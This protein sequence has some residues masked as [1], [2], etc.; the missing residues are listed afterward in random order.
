MKYLNDLLKTKFINASAQIG[1]SHLSL[2]EATRWRCRLERR[3][4]NQLRML[5]KSLRK[6][7]TERQVG[8]EKSCSAQD[9]KRENKGTQTPATTRLKSGA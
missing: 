3:A 5:Q 4:K 1:S 2:L 6:R 7:G 8:R 9:Y